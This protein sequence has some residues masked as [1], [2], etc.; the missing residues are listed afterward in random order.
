[1]NRDVEMALAER[2]LDVGAVLWL[3]GAAVPHHDRSASVLTLGDD[4][5]EV[6]V[7]NRMILDGHGEPLDGGIE[8][9]SLRNG[10]RLEH[11][12]GLEPEIIV[13]LTRAMLL[14]DEQAPRRRSRS[15]RLGLRSGFEASLARIRGERRTF[16]RCRV[17]SGTRSVSSLCPHYLRHDHSSSGPVTTT[18]DKSHPRR[19]L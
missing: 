3:V 16:R 1:M 5:L 17:G 18:C 19:A 15:T 8:R 9:G 12:A 13:E 10:P 14:D 2:C 6:R 11:A 4:A 7:G